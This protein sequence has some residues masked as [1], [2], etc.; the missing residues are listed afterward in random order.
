MTD[1][2]EH[3]EQVD[4]WLRA[5]P[6]ELSAEQFLRRFELV[7]NKIVA[8]A[9]VT[10]GEVTLTA[11]LDRV[12]YLAAEKFPLASAIKV[13]WTSVSC[14]ELLEPGSARPLDQLVEAIRFILTAF[15]TLLGK[16]T[17]EVLTPA[18][19]AELM[20][21]VEAKQDAGPGD[22]PADGGRRYDKGV[23]S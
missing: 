4:A 10:L 22:A 8:R 6:K 3:S 5:A 18:L 2:N 15:L 13:E 17:A 14:R 19:H 1:G 16:L 11:I 20:R 9:Q 23:A 12:V 7:F 21:D